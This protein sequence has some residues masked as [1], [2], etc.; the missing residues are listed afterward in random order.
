[1]RFGQA[2]RAH[3]GKRWHVQLVPGESG[4]VRTWRIRGW[5]LVGLA[6]SL[7]LTIAL[8]FSFA[9]YAWLSR[10]RMHALDERMAVEKSM[11][12]MQET[13]LK[14]DRA[15]LNDENR[16]LKARYDDLLKKIQDLERTL[17]SNEERLKSL[18]PPTSKRPESAPTEAVFLAANPGTVRIAT[19]SD[20]PEDGV[21]AETLID[22]IENS[23][24]ALEAA[25][26]EQAR[27][28]EETAQAVAEYREKLSRL[29]TIRPAV[30][31]VTSVFGLR[32]DPFTKTRRFHEGIDFANAVG[33]P[34]RAAA[35]GKIV[36]A[37]RSGDYGQMIE[38]DHGN[39]LSTVYAHLSKM[40][41]RPGDVVE[42]GQTIGRMGSTGR[43]TGPHLHFEVR[44]GGRPID[45]AP[46][47]GGDV[48]VEEVLAQD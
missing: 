42:K 18:A 34:I 40:L 48:H 38:I 10:A 19:L 25:A 22:T 33:T 16:A 14:Q 8:L 30:G 43:S 37:G 21:D 46:F 32:A 4:R 31:R 26:D 7:T 3:L 12:E 45:P 41:V 35:K 27:S 2:L 36:F 13:R 23:L 28:V 17:E 9:T 15:R 5:T 6:A 1:M 20:R 29:P 39:G 11:Q 44:R 24:Q 47:L